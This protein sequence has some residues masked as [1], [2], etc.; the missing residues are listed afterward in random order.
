M[1][2]SNNAIMITMLNGEWQINSSEIR[3]L[4]GRVPGS[5]LTS[6]LDNDLIGEPSYRDNAE[7]IR[8]KYLYE[9]YT[10]SRKFSLS[11]EQL[12]KHNYLFAEGID[13]VASIFINGVKIADVCDMFMRYR[14][15]VDN[16]V[17]S[18]ENEIKIEFISP[19]KYIAEHA[20]GLFRTFGVTELKA[21]CIRKAGYSFGWDWCANLADMG[22]YRDIYLVSTDEGYLSDYKYTAE[23]LPDG[24][25]KLCVTV[26]SVCI[27]KGEVKVSLFGHGYSSSL[28]KPLSETTIFEFL[29]DNPELWYPNG[30]GKQSLYNLKIQVGDKEYN[31]KLGLR[32]IEVDDKID[33]VGRN[34][35]VYV[36]G[37]KIFVKGSNYIPEDLVLGRI[38]EKRT[39][40]LLTRVA[41]N[42]GNT[43]R[44][45]GGGLYPD[46]Y[47]YDICDELGLLVF[48]DLTFACAA[49]DMRDEKFKSLI[50]NETADALKRI[51][52]HACICVIDGDNECEDGINGNGEDIMEQYS[53]M[54]GIIT[55]TVK[56]NCDAYFLPS[57]PSSGK[58]FT[59]QND[60]ENMDTH[61]WSVWHGLKPYED[62][63]EISPRLLSEFGIQ[64]FPSY[65]TVK[66]FTRQNERY[67]S[68]YVMT[69][70][71]RDYSF[72]NDKNIYYVDKYY[73]KPQ[74][75][76]ELCYLSSL[77]QAEGLKLCV[78][79]LR[80]NKPR[81]NGAIYWQLNDC[82]MGQS[83]SG[84]DY[85]GM[86]KAA[87]YYER[88]FFAPHIVVV[89]ERENEIVIGI[90]NDTANDT[91]YNV[92]YEFCSFDGE[93]IE[94]K[95]FSAFVSASSCGV[96]YKCKSPFG[97]KDTD[98]Y[99]YVRIYNAEGEVLS[100]TIY[101]KFSD[102]KIIYPKV[103]IDIAQSDSTHFTVKTNGFAKNVY[104]VCGDAVFSDNFFTLRKGE[105][106]IV[107]TN[108]PV[109]KDNIEI[110]TLNDLM[111]TD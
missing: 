49:Y 37:I 52:N 20:G 21:P 27:G 23:F 80:M 59:R 12:K 74:D 45:W 29:I 66:K 108:V 9:N 60:T 99:V 95:A 57:S 85:C 71:Q 79:H 105:E 93:V 94:S 2:R 63:A 77:V 106:R 31:Y 26:N 102:K 76:K 1:R 68:S 10:F 22:I 97:D 17:L 111:R 34:F 3:N 87:N 18:T 107:T 88:N 28:A 75:L 69:Y 25:A 82:W 91:K 73:K 110:V 89:S 58:M 39:R 72:T 6:L 43:V 11:E 36:N 65:E 103:K 33:N 47:F 13:T 101:Q 53:V 83:E 54:R 40:N 64:S 41:N 38:N 55:E 67:A 48:Q 8:E 24:K 100:R 46:D 42:Y 15:K 19:Y 50:V 81:C 92:K 5:L 86:P 51:R 104:L 30:Y 44:V 14:I 62:Y 90:S 109:N 35:A 16:S 32:K 98:K 96:V 70:H 78:E 4:R 56:Q 84:I 7:N 61:Y